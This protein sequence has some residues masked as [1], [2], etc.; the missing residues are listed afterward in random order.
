[1]VY[2]FEDLSRKEPI[3]DFYDIGK[4]LGRGASSVVKLCRQKGTN[5]EFA[6]K[7]MKKTVDKK[8]IQTETG[9]LFR[10]NHPN[11][12]HMKELFE[13]HT[14]LFMVL[15][16]VTGGE[17]FDRVV[18]KGYYCEKD[19]ADA[20]KMILEAV[21]HLHK[22][23]IVHRD[24]KPENL[25]YANERED[26]PLKIA[27]F[28]LSKILPQEVMT[29]TVCGTPGYCAPE[30][31]KGESY[32][33]G[34]DMWAI[35]V[36]AYILLCGFEPFYDETDQQ[37]FQRILKCDYDFV[38]PWWDDVSSGAK[39]LVKRLITG[40]KNKRLTAKQALD[41]PWVKGENARREDMERTR[42]KLKEFNAKRKLK[43]GMLGVMAAENFAKGFA[44]KS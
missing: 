12:I 4:E 28:G 21:G 37:M 27:D 42:K 33:T 41:H 14:H 5:K 11:I 7:I 19:A 3:E 13:T 6:V 36:I 40:D 38:S 16:L 26:S 31:L 35:G 25:L 8:I 30:V 2:F 23:D 9:I 29:S 24:L 18:E 43:G 20:I 17:L 32:D 39:D 10:I 34:V 22:N 1:M 44:K 15:E